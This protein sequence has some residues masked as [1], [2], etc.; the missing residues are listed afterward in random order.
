MDTVDALEPVFCLGDP[1]IISGIVN[2]TRKDKEENATVP[3]GKSKK[4]KKKKKVSL[5]ACYEN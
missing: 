3:N 4:K 2:L 5:L 1:N